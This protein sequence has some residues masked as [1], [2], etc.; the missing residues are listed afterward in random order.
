MGANNIYKSRFHG[1]YWAGSKRHRLLHRIH[2][3]LDEMLSCYLLA[4][5]DPRTGV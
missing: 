2:N 3:K 4:Y 5:V 1:P